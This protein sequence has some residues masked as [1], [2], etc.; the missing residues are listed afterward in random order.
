MT[1]SIP[2]LVDSC[3]KV[4]VKRGYCQSHYKKV[5]RYGDPIAGRGP[6]AANG[7]P[8]KFI[9]DVALKHDNDDCLPW[10]YGTYPSG[11]AKITVDG[12]DRTASSYVCE[13]T[14]GPA[15]SPHHESAHSCGN[16]ICVNRWH[17]RWKT[18]A[19]NNADKLL[20]G[21]HNRGERHNLAKLTEG[22]VH[23]IRRLRGI[24]TE[25]E[26]ADRFGVSSTAIR[27]IHAGK[28]WSWLEVQGGAQ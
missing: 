8:Q 21:T 20:H 11:Y 14:H 9:E 3:Q 16:R 17:T 23:E 19:E 12:H 6:R 15:P 4:S 18:S 7:A 5:W 22:N 1:N 26:L 25:R 28:N 24:E 13:L 10:P 27:L 2:C